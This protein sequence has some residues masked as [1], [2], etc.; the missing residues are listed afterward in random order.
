MSK[1]EGDYFGSYLRL[2]R[3]A[4]YGWFCRGQSHITEN[5]NNIIIL[6]M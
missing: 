6:A 5:S 4:Q 2:R 3:P 1:S